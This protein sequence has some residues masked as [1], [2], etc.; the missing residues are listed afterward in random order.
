MENYQE[1]IEKQIIPL[2]SKP[3]RY[4]GN[5]IHVIKKDWSETAVKFG[6][7]FP[8]L[9]EIGMSHIGFEILYHI[10]NKMDDTVAERIY[11]PADDVEEKLREKNLPLF[12]LESKQPLQNF[13][14]LGFT[15]QYEL[16][17]TNVLNILDLGQIPVYRKE[18]D[19]QYPLIIAGGPCA[20]NPEPLADFMD[21]FVVGDG[22]DVVGEF[23]EFIKQSKK[24]GMPR[25]D[26]LRKLAQIRGVYVP[27][28]YQPQY[29]NGVFK[30]VVKLKEDVPDKVRARTVDG[31]KA[32]YYPLKPLVPLIESTHDR[33]SVEIM[34]GCTQGCRFCNAGYVYRP[35]RERS[36][37]DLTRHIETVIRNTGYDEISL[38]SLSTSDYSQL[39]SLLNRLNRKLEPLMVN[40][41]FPSLRTETF[42]LEMARYAKR[43]KKSGIT[44]APEAGTERLRKIINKTNTNED[45]LR[46][47]KIAFQE[48]WNSI[49]LYFMIGQP[50]EEKEDMD[51][52]IDLIK[53]VKKVAK[54][55]RGKAINISISPFCPK[56]NTPFQWVVQD[57]VEEMKQKIFYL[58]DNLTDPMIKLSWRDPE[59]SLIEGITARGDRRLGSVIY[60]AWK[61]GAKFDS[62]GDHFNYDIWKNAFDICQIDSNQYTR[63]RKLDEPL[64]WDHIQKGVNKE[65]L[66]KEYQKAQSVQTT[67][68]C[69]ETSC[70]GCGLMAHAECQEI[71][72]SRAHGKTEQ[73]HFKDTA[74]STNVNY[75]RSRKRIQTASAPVPQIVRLKYRKGET[76]RFTSH[77]DVVRIFERAFRRAG[78]NLAYS[79]GFHPHPKIAYSPPLPVGYTSSSE[80]LDVQYFREH[81]QDLVRSVNRVLPK[82]LE[83]IKSVPLLAKQRSLS[84]MINLSEYRVILPKSFDQS[85]LNKSI[86]EYLGRDE[87]IVDRVK[88]NATVSL[89]IR[90]YI[91]SIETGKEND[92][93]HI[94][95]NFDQGRTARVSEILDGMLN[96]TEDEIA[97]SQVERTNLAVKV[98][99]IVMSPM[100]V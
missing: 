84:A 81:S 90:P 14:V 69:R 68:D 53:M 30:G 83:F 12:S 51:G 78:V 26:V 100:D 11:A 1:I 65:F 6:L 75:G 34:R 88:A 28:F 24:E 8:D 93:L 32:D 31:L 3:G 71:I 29:E 4:V 2:V 40:V 21:A 94:T 97:L 95:V 89:D 55:N 25:G 54:Q 85:Y 98:G 82:G 70:H 56:S 63:E 18:R 61:D 38:A 59:V 5:E 67:E 96:L 7:V 50:G 76:V 87:I 43:V 79:Q 33:Y 91:E 73:F 20:F 86:N 60:Q 74:D 35:V 39:P 48:G 52:I 41:S 23:V 22:E 64:P 37:D 15:L 62:W 13:D 72:K 42:T 57:S 46:A 77:L 58:K 49:K 16:H 27:E 36:V 47:V 9:Y 80:Y 92:T 99:D 10:L 66:K 17:F 44:L 19:G 45:L